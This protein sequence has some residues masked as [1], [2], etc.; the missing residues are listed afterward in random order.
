M[1]KRIKGGDISNLSEK[2]SRRK[3]DL[4]FFKQQIEYAAPDEKKNN[5]KTNGKF[6]K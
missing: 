6:R 4:D 3:A 1:S 2:I 5:S